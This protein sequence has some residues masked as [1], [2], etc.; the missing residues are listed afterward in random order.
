[1]VWAMTS[2]TPQHRTRWTALG[3]IVAITLGAGGVGITNAVVD[4]GERTSFVPITPC[5]LADT[6]ATE[7]VGPRNT[8]IGPGG[9]HTITA[10]GTNGNC[11]IPAGATAL[12]LNVTAFNPTIETFLTVYPTGAT[13]PTT[14]NLNPKPGQPPTPNAVTVDINAT[15]QFDIYNL[16]GSV[17]VIVDVVG[18]YEDHNH[19][20]RYYTKA[21][22]DSNIS[23]ASSAANHVGSSQIADGSVTLADLKSATRDA[24][25]DF[26]A[27]PVSLAP[28]ACF[29]RAP[30]D[31]IGTGNGPFAGGKLVTATF[32]TT[33][34]STN[35]NLVPGTTRTNSLGFGIA[36]IQFCNSGTGVLLVNAVIV[37][38]ITTFG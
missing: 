6:R 23:A 20:D 29:V 11:T 17:D 31:G 30:G 15:G 2:A 21:Q 35:L 4:S 13:R 38:R 19:D 32:V 37:V 33:G 27:G 5:R 34:L 12:S 25:I 36:P 14:S 18:Y 1:M 10:H 8:P 26:S 22:T 9:T 16:G 3:A 7:Q 24:T 28:G